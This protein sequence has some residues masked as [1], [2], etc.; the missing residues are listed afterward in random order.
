MKIIVLG[1]DGFCGWPSS[2]HLSKLGFEVLI[3]DNLS[4]RNI[5]NELEVSSLTPIKPI[6]ERIK[7]W[8]ETTG[9]KIDFVNIDVAN[10]YD[11]LL[12]VINNFCPDA[13]IHFAIFIRSYSVEYHHYFSNR[14][15]NIDSIPKFQYSVNNEY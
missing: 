12:P 8:K 11:K 2:L 15:L 4:R 1:G 14:I 13:I 5:D 10:D 6:G 9:K 3:I 7:A